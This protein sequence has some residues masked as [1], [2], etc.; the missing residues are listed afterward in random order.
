MIA[1]RAKGVKERGL[2]IFEKLWEKP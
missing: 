2:A 1:A